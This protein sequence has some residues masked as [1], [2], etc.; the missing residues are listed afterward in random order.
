MIAAAY[1]AARRRT[2]PVSLSRISYGWVGSRK[3]LSVPRGC[4]RLGRVG[5]ANSRPGRRFVGYHARLPG[6]SV[7]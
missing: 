2:I 1:D 7:S 4:Q 3:V 5:S 6:F